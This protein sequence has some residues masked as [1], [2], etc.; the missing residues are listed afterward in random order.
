MTLVTLPQVVLEMLKFSVYGSGGNTTKGKSGVRK[1][2]QISNM[3]HP[4][5][6][7]AFIALCDDGSLWLYHGS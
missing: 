7:C 2:V 6:D 3:V 4:E 1:V 5:K